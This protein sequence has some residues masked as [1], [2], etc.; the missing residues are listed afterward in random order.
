VKSF[1]RD[2]LKALHVDQNLLKCV[3][4]LGEY[5]GKQDLF[6][7]QSPQTLRTLKENAVIQSTESSNRIEGVEI[8]DQN[9]FMSLV[10]RQVEPMTR[11]EQEI[12]GYRDT[13]GTIHD[14]HVNIQFSANLVLQLHRDLFQYANEPG[15]KWKASDNEITETFPDGSKHVRFIPVPSRQTADAMTTLHRLFREAS[16][17]A[18]AIEPLIAIPAYVLDFL[19]IHPFRDGNGRMA[20][21]VSL[22]LLYQAGYDVGAYIGLERLVEDTKD[23]YYDALY[24][25]SQ[26]WHEGQHNLNPWLEYFLGV[27]LLGAYREFENRVGSVETAR[28]AKAAMILAEVKRLPMRFTISDVMARCPTVGIDYVRKILRV[29]RDSGRLRSDGRGPDAAWIKIQ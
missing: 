13:L 19:C 21:L 27:M 4:L 2:R 23:G 7:V 26:G 24:R 9:R 18:D 29:E 6:R 22:L 28:G 17:S 1:E 11:S 8:H 16:E 15:G 25:S 14:S 12:A 3:R 10:N 5:R 20:R